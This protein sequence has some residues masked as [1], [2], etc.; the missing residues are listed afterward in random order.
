MSPNI[1]SL[2]RVIGFKTTESI[3]H[4]FKEEPKGEVEQSNCASILTWGYQGNFTLNFY[5]VH[6]ILV[7]DYFDALFWNYHYD[8]TKQCLSTLI[9]SAFKIQ[10]KF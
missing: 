6:E 9:I 7:L 3:F 8:L 1:Y 2:T 10:D 5:L 4:I